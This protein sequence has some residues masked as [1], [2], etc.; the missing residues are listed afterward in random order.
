MIRTF[1]FAAL[2][3]IAV[4]MGHLGGPRDEHPHKHHGDG[5]SFLANVSAEGKQEFEKVF[6]NK[7][8]TLAE[9]EVQ[10]E[11]LA[12]KYGVSDIYKEFQAKRTARLAEVKKNQTEVI[13]NL[14]DVSAQLKTIYQNKNQTAAEQ[15]KAVEALRK[16]HRVEVDTI[17]FIRA[18]FGEHKRH[19]GRP[20]GGSIRPLVLP[21]ESHVGPTVGQENVDKKEESA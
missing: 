2:A 5:P 14:S 20:H 21:K 12:A 9:G 19:A 3:I 16:E 18:Q 8:L 17:K 4:V 1:T 11:A 6:K 13:H 15:E 7:Q 10:I